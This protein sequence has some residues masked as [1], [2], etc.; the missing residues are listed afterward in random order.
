MTVFLSNL[1]GIT[2]CLLMCYALDL[3]VTFIFALNG[4]RVMQL[5]LENC[6]KRHILLSL[7]VSPFL[8]L[9]IVLYLLIR[10]VLGSG[11]TREETNV[12][13]MRLYSSLK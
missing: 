7:V 6:S 8:L 13:M 9:G 12:R 5:R 11:K 2:L 1:C 4:C 10:L 3:A